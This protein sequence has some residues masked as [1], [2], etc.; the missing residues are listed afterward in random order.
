MTLTKVEILGERR[1]KGK[2]K[3]GLT[4]SRKNR[5]VC[6]VVTRQYVQL[7]GAV[8]YSLVISKIETVRSSAPPCHAPQ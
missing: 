5:V 4:L 2:A 6:P 8:Q 3:R 1:G 7:Y